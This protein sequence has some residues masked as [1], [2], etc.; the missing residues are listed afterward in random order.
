MSEYEEVSEYETESE[1][2]KVDTKIRKQIS[3]EEEDNEEG[4][5]PGPFDAPAKKQ[6]QVVKGVLSFRVKSPISRDE[7]RSRDAA[8]PG[9]AAAGHVLLTPP[10]AVDLNPARDEVAASAGNPDRSAPAAVSVAAELFPAV[11]AA[12]VTPP[13]AVD[14]PPGCGSGRARD[15]AFETAGKPDDEIP[16]KPPMPNFAPPTLIEPTGCIA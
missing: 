5:I 8:K 12:V 1:D 7:I 3:G 11:P 16:G 4:E 2:E 9:P 10:S 13:S 6:Q 15:G 14:L